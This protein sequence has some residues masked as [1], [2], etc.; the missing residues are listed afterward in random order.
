MSAALACVAERATYSALSTCSID[1]Q[2]Y[3]LGENALYLIR[4]RTWQ[5]R[6]DALV[7]E[8]N[9]SAALRLATDL[10]TGKAVLSRAQRPGAT[11]RQ[12]AIA[13]RIV[14]FSQLGVELSKQMLWAGVDAGSVGQSEIRRERFLL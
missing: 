1:A 6:V 2:I 5:Q 11:N 13:E 12:H 14:G 9:Y 3:L 7:D 10:Y 8:N 4:L